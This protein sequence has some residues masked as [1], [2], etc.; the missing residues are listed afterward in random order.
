MKN[1]DSTTATIE[2]ENEKIKKIFDSQSN[3]LKGLIVLAVVNYVVL[4]VVI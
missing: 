1:F 2:N 3:F 4:L